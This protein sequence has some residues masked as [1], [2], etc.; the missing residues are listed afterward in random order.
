MD[1]IDK[2][3]LICPILYAPS[4]IKQ[5]KAGHFGYFFHSLQVILRAWYI[6]DIAV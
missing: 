4:G 2:Y 3:V 5:M 6:A 1:D